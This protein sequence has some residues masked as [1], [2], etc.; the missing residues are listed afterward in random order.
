MDIIATSM[1]VGYL[2]AVTLLG[3]VLALRSKTS[4]QRRH[5]CQLT[6]RSPRGPH[7]LDDFKRV[8]NVNPYLNN[9]RDADVFWTAIRPADEP[10]RHRWFLPSVAVILILSVPWYLPREVGDRLVGGLPLWTWITVACA[11]VLSAL[12]AWA[13][14]RLW[15]DEYESD[16]GSR[17]GDHERLRRSSPKLNTDN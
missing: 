15:R 7:N 4:S 2:A 3:I 13:S 17:A 6:D 14:L 12:M 1:I 11:A 9:E 10:T 16:S 5:R 8:I